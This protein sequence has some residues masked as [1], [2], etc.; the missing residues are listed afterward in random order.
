VHVQ[1]R[2]RVP[3]ILL[4]LVGVS[5]LPVGAQATAAPREP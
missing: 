4:R 3:T 2:R 5:T 1:V